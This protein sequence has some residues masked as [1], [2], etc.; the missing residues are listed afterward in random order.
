MRHIHDGELHAFLDGALDLLP[1]GRGEEIRE[2]L[3]E[4][5]AC[6]ERLQDE[7]AVRTQAG[8]LMGEPDLGS[9]TLPSFEEMRQLDASR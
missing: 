5:S 7:E 4:C 6:R 9:V 1:E 3:S 8:D 2:H